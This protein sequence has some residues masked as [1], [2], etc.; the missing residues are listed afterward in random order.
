MQTVSAVIPAY[1]ASRVLP[2]CLEALAS[3]RLQPEEILVV[4]DGPS[5]DATAAVARSRG[6]R[7]LSMARQLGPGGARNAGVA[8]ASGEIVVFIDSDVCVRPDAIGN[9]V[10][11]LREHPDVDAV[12]GSYDT[13]PPERN[14]TSQ[15]KNL[16]HHYVHQQ[17]RED[18]TTFWA[19]LGAVRRSPFEAVGGFDAARYGR[20]SIE[21]IELGHRL[22]AAGSRVRLV[23]SAQ[24]THLKR[25]TVA[26]MLKTD[27]FDRAIPWT[28]LI[29]SSGQ[30]P[31]DLNLGWRHRMGVAA[32]GLAIAA[33]VA[34]LFAPRFWIVA[35]VM[36]TIAAASGSDV[37]VF[38]ARQRGPFFALRAIPLHI[39]YF[40]AS[41]L[42]FA[43]GLGQYWKRR[44]IP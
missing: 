19:G 21:D 18:A 20:P 43:I 34:A 31:D 11:F 40:A 12:F 2:A 15:Y 44:W 22:L 6:A 8:A 36:L 30:M 5:T 9:L 3:S 41:G 24:G 28:E 13:S 23:K 26:G 10:G 42:A 14:F 29:L 25:W 1:Q 38:F 16:L 7:V 4:D 32:T 17:G 27:V 39:A 33:A 37:F 35:A